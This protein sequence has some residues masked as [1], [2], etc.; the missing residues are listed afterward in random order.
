M[1]TL[2]GPGGD[3]KACRKRLEK[4]EREEEKEGKMRIWEGK[5]KKRINEI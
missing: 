3:I 4:N 1:Y 5:T 2:L